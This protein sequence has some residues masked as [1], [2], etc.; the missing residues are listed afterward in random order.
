MIGEKKS[1]SWN[2]KWLN[3]VIYGKFKVFFQKVRAESVLANR[4]RGKSRFSVKTMWVISF[5][6][7]WH[8]FFCGMGIEYVF[9]F[10]F[11]YYR[12]YWLKMPSTVSEPLALLK[13]RSTTTFP[14]WTGMPYW[15]WRLTSFPSWKTTKTPPTLTWGRSGTTTR[16]WWRPTTPGPR[17]RTPMTPKCP[18]HHLL[19]LRQDTGVFHEFFFNRKVSNLV[20]K[21]ILFT[22]T[23]LIPS[24]LFRYLFHICFRQSS[25][26]LSI[27]K[28]ILVK[29]QNS[30]PL[31]RF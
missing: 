29:Q 17:P 16:T 3:V 14:L 18:F 12:L 20:L 24:L 31:E 19:L 13:L 26:D 27:K 21:L 30:W 4:K 1:S 23:V 28:K 10:Y 9:N 22:K 11:T 25:L 7:N 5:R 6:K 15:G 2:S 8:R